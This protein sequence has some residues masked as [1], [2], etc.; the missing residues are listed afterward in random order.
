MLRWIEKNEARI[1]E[2]RTAPAKRLF[3][4]FDFRSRFRCCIHNGFAGE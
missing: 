2:L 1:A 3:A 4:G